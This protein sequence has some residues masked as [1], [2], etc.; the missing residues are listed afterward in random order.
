MLELD[1]GAIANHISACGTRDSES[2]GELWSVVQSGT[3]MTIALEEISA[4]V[5]KSDDQ[6]QCK[7]RKLDAR[8]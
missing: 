6:Y 1:G 2:R 3:S 5:I 4:C 8:L 7:K